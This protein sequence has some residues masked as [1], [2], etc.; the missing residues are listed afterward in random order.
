MRL[1]DDGIFVV[2]EDDF[3]FIFCCCCRDMWFRMDPPPFEEGFVSLMESQQ[4][5]VFP[6]SI[7]TVQLPDDASF[8]DVDEDADEASQEEARLDN[9]Y[10]MQQLRNGLY[11]AIGYVEE[12]YK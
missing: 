11:N 2:E 3:A 4:I 8:R 9:E 10:W 6:G 12:D 5:V 1:E 7:Q